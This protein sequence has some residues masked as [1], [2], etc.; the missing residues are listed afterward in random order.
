VSEY[1]VSATEQPEVSPREQSPAEQ[2]DAVLM[3]E[4]RYMYALGIMKWQLILVLLIHHS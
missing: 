1:K 2:S 4:K 3:S